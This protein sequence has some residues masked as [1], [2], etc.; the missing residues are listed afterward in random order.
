MV[1][2]VLRFV[3]E[4]E[5]EAEQAPESQYSTAYLDALRLVKDYILELMWEEGIDDEEE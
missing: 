1:R 4:T 5:R 2:Q 3:R